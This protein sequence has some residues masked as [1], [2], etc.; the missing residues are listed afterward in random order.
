MAVTNFDTLASQISDLSALTYCGSIVGTE[1]GL[2]NV[3]GLNGFASVGDM[4]LL[5][6]DQ[7]QQFGEVVSL[8][9][10]SLAILPAEGTR[11][12]ALKAPVRL[13]ADAGIAPDRSWL[14]RVIDP[15]GNPLDHRPISRGRAPAP[16]RNTP[17]LAA[18][19]HRLG[20]RL[21]TG[22]AAFNT[23]LPLVAGQRLGLFSGSGIGKSSLLADLCRGVEADVI[24]LALIG[25]RGR[26]LRE[27][28][29][30]VLGPEG[31]K[32]T[33]IMAATSDQSA[34]V[35]RRSAWA[36][37]AVAEHFR[38]RGAQVLYLCDSLTR[39]AEAHREVAVSCGEAMSAGG[40]PPSTTQAVM[41]LCERA[42]P[43]SAQNG[44]ITAIFSVL[45]AGSDMEEPLSDTVRGVLDGHVVLDR[46]IAERG[47]FPA[48]DVLR[49][50]SRSLP[51]A[52]SEAENEI[53]AK[54]RLSMSAYADVEL[55]LQAGL[56]EMGSNPAFDQAIS[57]RPKMEAFLAQKGITV[58]ESF[59][60]LEALLTQKQESDDTISG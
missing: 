8:K 57:E 26:E 45:V 44:D 24:V 14:G 5:P 39:F 16:L 9:S 38:D 42:G 59:R 32:R 18:D 49:S 10:S 36:S 58:D 27:F 37:M 53:L 15:F 23:F 20:P 13:L 55:M 3:A 46:K 7:G 31:L 33:V 60:M 40:Y 2:V 54:A 52:A 25:E 1:G 28:A 50:V 30:D 51:A 43:G 35:R 56:Y 22:L 17:P 47:R 48:I 4:V 41:E 11:G 21:E 6:T 34:L 19:R 12:C 29:E